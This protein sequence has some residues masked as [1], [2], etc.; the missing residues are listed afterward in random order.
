M[1][2]AASSPGQ[3]P[4]AD[5]LPADQ[6]PAYPPPAYPPLARR[7]M[8]MLAV[9][10]GAFMTQLDVTIAN[11]ALPHMQ[12]STSSSRE[13]I[14]WVLTSYI[15]MAATF[16]PLS[17]WLAG[18]IG[19]RMVMVISVA[20]FTAASALCGMAQTLDQ[21]IAFRLLQGIMGSALVPISQ[22]IV[23]DINPPEQHG[24]AMALWGIGTVLGP[25][26]G[27]LAGG[28]LTDNLNWRWVFYINVP[29][30][31]LTVLGLLAFMRGPDVRLRQGLD[32]FGFGLLAVAVCALQLMLDRGQSQGWFDSREIWVEAVISVAAFYTVIVHSLTSRRP[33]LA[34]ALF[35]DRNF[36]A[37]NVLGM[38]QGAVAYGVIALLAPMLAEL[39]GYPVT[40]VGLVTAPRGVGALLA[41]LLAGRLLKRVDA[42]LLLLAGLALSAISA[43][44]M[45]M[46]SLAMD[47]RLLIIAGLIQGLG[48]GMM[49]VPVFAII[50]ATIP[51]RL[52][53]EGAA[54]GSLMRGLGG[55]MSIAIL[56]AI[57]AHNEAVTHARLVERLRPDNPLL[58]LRLPGFDFSSTR[59]VAM[60]HAEISRQALMVAYIDSFWLLCVVGV[61]VMPLV[62]LVRPAK[63]V[64]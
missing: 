8:I 28:W 48:Q 19:R 52:R 51:E 57:T 45:A 2:A 18:R 13:Q 38:F 32:M 36:L 5:Q 34:P 47:S 53:N 61:A 24:P 43:G 50:F 16:T 12:A 41:M 3:S 59:A 30:G 22:A 15:I 31:I 58:A 4:Q 29:I 6:L 64:K 35:T 39:M 40:L 7:R 54:M 23:L 55:A 33:F 20:G 26:V 1:T 21:I 56:Q 46:C 63:R 42:R 17:G 11:V 62:L 60:I 44:M 9:L 49:S 10:T 25:I 14:S 27:P 37:G